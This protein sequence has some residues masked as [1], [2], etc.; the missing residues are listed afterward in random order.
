MGIDV[1]SGTISLKQKE[2]DW[3]HMLAQGQSSL[4]EEK[5]EWNKETPNFIL[6]ASEKYLL[7][8]SGGKSELCWVYVL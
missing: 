7:P 8:S 3:Q 5:K 4:L 6:F 1:N 2:E